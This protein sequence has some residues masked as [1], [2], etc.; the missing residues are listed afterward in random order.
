MKEGN[1]M[2][3]KIRNHRNN[4]RKKWLELREMACY[5]KNIETGIKLREEEDKIYKLWLFYDK[6]LKEKVG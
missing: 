5:S 2:N 4:L 1:N 6:I 3:R